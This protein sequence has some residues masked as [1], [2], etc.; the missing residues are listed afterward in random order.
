MKPHLSVKY[1][2]MAT[3][4]LLAALSVQAEPA[5]R[6]V[7]RP[8]PSAPA[9]EPV[10]VGEEVRTS[11][12]ERRRLQLSDGSVLYLNRETAL[13][14]EAEREVRLSAGEVFVEAGEALTVQTPA[15]TVRGSPT[16]F[17]VN[18]IVENS[19]NF[20]IEVTPARRSLISGTEKLV[21]AMVRSAAFCPM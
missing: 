9:V 7:S 11:K 17:I 15:R 5:D 18:S 10:Q 1:A 12:D 3:A 13:K 20:S 19:P 21:C 8:R 14:L 16:P 2:L 4:V 6:L